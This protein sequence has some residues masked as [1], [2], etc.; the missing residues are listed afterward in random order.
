[1]MITRIEYE[2]IG[3]DINGFRK[4][5]MHGIDEH[6]QPIVKVY[7]DDNWREHALQVG[8]EW[9]GD[10]KPNHHCL[11][12]SYEHTIPMPAGGRTVDIDYCIADIVAALIASNI[13]TVA[14]C[15][16][17]GKADGSIML[18]DGREIKI[19]GT[20]HESGDKHSQGEKI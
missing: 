8:M 2:D 9:K 10:L 17:H 5:R 15:C 20:A 13:P 11:V 3:P 12:G 16:G 1:M 18:A 6:E 14:S 19:I 7:H 4:Y